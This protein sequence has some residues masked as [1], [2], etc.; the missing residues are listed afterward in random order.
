MYFGH[1]PDNL[2]TALIK[3]VDIQGEQWQIE[4]LVL[5]QRDLTIQG[6]IVDLS[7]VIS[8]AAKTVHKEKFSQ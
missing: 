4:T 6:V 3:G 5:I 8:V 7:G 1:W 2:S